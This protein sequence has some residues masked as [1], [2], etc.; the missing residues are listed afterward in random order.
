MD[1]FALS[2]RRLARFAVLVA[3]PVLAIATDSRAH[4]LVDTSRG[5]LSFGW[6]AQPWVVVS[7]TASLAAYV[8]GYVRLRRRGARRMQSRRLRRAY[9][10]A[11]VAGWAALALAF[12]SPLDALG[13]ALFSA[14]MVQHEA[15]M[16]VAAPLCAMGRP[17]GVWIWALPH[18]ARL[19]V[20]QRIRTRG[21]VRFWHMLTM[22]ITAW[23]LHA[24][25]LWAWHAPAL[26]EAVLMRPWVHT[27]QHAS[28]LLTA[29]LFWWS[30][31]GEGARRQ[32]DGHAMLSL[33]TTMMHTGAL[34]ALIT[35][36]PQLW[37]P[38]YVEPCSALGVDPLN[39]QQLGGLIMWVPA[40]T[41]Y[42]VGALAIA[43]RWLMRR[44]APVLTAQ[45]AVIVRRDGVQ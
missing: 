35:L 36:A 22:P 7:M 2:L 44:D 18:R 20:G 30:I 40:T 12:F 4:G 15:M 41:A 24:A 10:L 29:L 43:T 21:F 37:Y 25:A 26:F 32:T 1:T 33:F 9:L 11:F 28:F 34:G 23:V 6:S 17:L 39:D 38:L 8:A 14:H 31:T 16:L 42:L 19:W 27:L 45:H 13:S 5:T 3:L